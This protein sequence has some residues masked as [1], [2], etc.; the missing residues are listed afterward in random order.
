LREDIPVTLTA[1][2]FTGGESRRMRADKAEL[3]VHDQPQWQRQLQVLRGLEPEAVFISA[4]KRPAWCPPDIETVPDEP[5]SRGPLSGLAAT[6]AKIRTT[7]LLALAVDLPAMTSVH[8]R[9]LWS[10][11]RSG[12]GVIP[13][14][15]DLFEP[16][17]AVYP[18]EAQALVNELLSGADASLQPFVRLL[19]ER[20]MA[21]PVDIEASE[22]ALYRN[23][24][25][26]A[27][28]EE[29]LNPLR[30][31]ASIRG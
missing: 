1:V 9:K 29:F 8:L 10:L 18:V 20:K 24:N 27:D 11:A 16:L 13:T 31:S 21:Q 26:P 30:S 6:L 28:R 12:C 19:V 3:I 17:C 4:R 14:H 2:L 7:H 15:N 22:H 25:T 5:P 23:L